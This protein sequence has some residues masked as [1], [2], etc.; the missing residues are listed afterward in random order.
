VSGV[1]IKYTW[2]DGQSYPD[3]ASMLQAGL[4]RILADKYAAME[5]AIRQKTC[6][7]HHRS[8]SVHRTRSGDKVS[9]RIEACCKQL[10]DLTQAAADLAFKG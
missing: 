9:F 4:D 3:G 5:R 10:R 6:P 7:V 1:T 8:A 2:S